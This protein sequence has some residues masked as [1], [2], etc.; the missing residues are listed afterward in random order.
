MTVALIS[1]LLQCSVWVLDQERG[2][3]PGHLDKRKKKKRTTLSSFD[4]QSGDQQWTSKT[5]NIIPL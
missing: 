3:G 4:K 2:P 1:P 5:Q